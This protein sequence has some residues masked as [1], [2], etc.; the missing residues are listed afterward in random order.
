MVLVQ[1]VDRAINARANLGI[2]DL[3]VTEV[4]IVMVNNY[5]MLTN[6]VCLLYL[7]YLRLYK[8]FEYAS[9]T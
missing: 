2:Q 6:C 3:Y 4:N 8:L 1:A 5:D 7:T 9:V